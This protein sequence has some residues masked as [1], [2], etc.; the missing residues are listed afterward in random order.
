MESGALPQAFS[1]L[2]C[3]SHDAAAAHAMR[4]C[5]FLEAVLGCDPCRSTSKYTLHTRDRLSCSLIAVSS[6]AEKL[7]ADLED[8]EK[9]C[10]QSADAAKRKVRTYNLIWQPA[11]Q[12]TS[13][14]RT[15]RPVPLHRGPAKPMVS[16]C[17]EATNFAVHVQQ[18]HWLGPFSSS[19]CAAIAD[20]Q[21]LS[22]RHRSVRT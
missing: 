13:Q 2:A 9:Q 19:I 5:C 18:K 4:W 11:L 6:P 1:A 20:I 21:K 7:R 3:H 8:R 17:S 22:C 14:R 16:A 10:K 15:S 12:Y